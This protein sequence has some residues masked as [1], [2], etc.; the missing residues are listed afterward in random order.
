MDYFT[1][2]CPVAKLNSIRVILSIASNFNYMSYQLDVKNAI[3]HGDLQE[4]VYAH[5]PPWLSL[6]G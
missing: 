3:L 6:E 1:F 2:F 4:K 5:S